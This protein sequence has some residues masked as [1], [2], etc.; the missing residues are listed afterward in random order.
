MCL[1]LQSN[2]V[3]AEYL[4]YNTISLFVTDLMYFNV[5][6]CFI[7]YASIHPPSNSMRSHFGSYRVLY[8][9]S[10]LWMLSHF[11]VVISS[12]TYDKRLSVMLSFKIFKLKT[13][14]RGIFY[15]VYNLRRLP[16]FVKHSAVCF[17]P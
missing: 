10:L 14:L 2:K 15:R 11:I 8:L 12:N 5:Y 3:S 16:Q 1:F 6:N 9:C 17:I 7:L 4:S 13:G